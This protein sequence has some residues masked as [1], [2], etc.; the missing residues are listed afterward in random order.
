[1][2]DAREVFA[3]PSKRVVSVPDKQG[4]EQRSHR[5]SH[6]FLKFGA[7]MRCGALSLPD[8]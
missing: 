2:C 5:E 8:T 4:G 1:M 3:F 6:E 7:V